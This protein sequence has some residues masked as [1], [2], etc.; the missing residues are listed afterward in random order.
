MLKAK[1]RLALDKGCGGVMFW[2]L[3]H[4]VSDPKTSLLNAINQEIKIRN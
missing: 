3:S 4:D 1:T 2:E